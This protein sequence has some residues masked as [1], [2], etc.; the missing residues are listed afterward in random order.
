MLLCL[1]DLLSVESCQIMED[2]QRPIGFPLPHILYHQTKVHP[3]P[4]QIHLC[5]LFIND[6]GHNCILSNASLC[7]LLSTIPVTFHIATTVVF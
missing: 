3:M 5:N 4:K 1:A 2:L 6:V 7:W